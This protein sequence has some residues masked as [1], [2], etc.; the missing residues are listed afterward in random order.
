MSRRPSALQKPKDYKKPSKSFIRP[1]SSKKNALG[2]ALL[3]QKESDFLKACENTDIDEIYKQIWQKVNLNC[4]KAI[5]GTSPLSLACRM[6]R[7]QV[8]SILLEFGA[9]VSAADDYGATPLH[10]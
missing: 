2:N 10:W 7:D 6:G 3:T 1:L 9:D 8:A 4:K 5:Y